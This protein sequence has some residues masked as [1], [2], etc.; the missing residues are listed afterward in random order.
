MRMLIILALM[1]GLAGSSTAQF[2][3]NDLATCFGRIEKEL[4]LGDTVT[5]YSDTGKV[6]GVYP[7]VSAGSSKLHL[8]PL[9]SESQT[10]IVIPLED[11]NGIKYTRPDAMG[12]TFGVIGF[13]AGSVCGALA[14][15]SLGSGSDRQ[16][17]YGFNWRLGKGTLAVVG[18]IVGAI[19]GTIIGSEIGG[20]IDRTVTLRCD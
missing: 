3:Q 1:T 11:I 7:V 14:G 18:G 9:N 10:E 6:R 5:V 19:F 17:S 20:T 4:R 13:V 15:A 2:K 8:K 16:G 12:T